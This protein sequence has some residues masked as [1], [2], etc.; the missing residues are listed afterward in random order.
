MHELRGQDCGVVADVRI[1]IVE[2]RNEVGD[3]AL[4]ECDQGSRDRRDISSR[5]DARMRLIP[6]EPESARELAGQRRE[7]HLAYRQHGEDEHFILRAG[8]TKRRN[9]L[10]HLFTKVDDD[11]RQ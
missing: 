3:R 8:I 2:Q 1:F 6:V 4:T 7:R 9:E 5:W 11:A 10:L